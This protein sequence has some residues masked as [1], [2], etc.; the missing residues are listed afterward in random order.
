MKIKK[1]IRKHQKH[2]KF[3]DKCLVDFQKQ[4]DKIKWDMADIVNYVI[5]K[6]KK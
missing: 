1:A 3:I 5:D 6:E 2:H 4:L